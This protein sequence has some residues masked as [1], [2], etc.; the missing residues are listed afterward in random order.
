MVQ[1]P[2]DTEHIE[3]DRRSNLI[4][5]ADTVTLIKIAGMP[6]EPADSLFV[7]PDDPV[8]SVGKY[9]GLLLDIADGKYPYA[10]DF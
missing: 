5:H 4:P 10:V 1:V 6:F 7:Y 2:G 8:I 3:T 9:I